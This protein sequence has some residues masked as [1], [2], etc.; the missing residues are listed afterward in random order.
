MSLGGDD[1]PAAAWNLRSRA[2]TQRKAD[3][4]GQSV[5]ARGL[6]EGAL[7]APGGFA[8]LALEGVDLPGNVDELFFGEHAGL[9]DL[10]GFAI[11]APPCGSVLHRD[12]LEPAFP[13]TGVLPVQRLPSYSAEG[14]LPRAMRERG[15]EATGGGRRQRR[16]K[17]GWDAGTAPVS[18]TLGQFHGAPRS[19]RFKVVLSS[20]SD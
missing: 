20:L 1:I 8:Q 4:A 18:W 14:V 9:G 5:K 15:G 12:R 10:M 17:S 19:D 3:D 11:G 6:R 2:A 13:G 16:K 7:E